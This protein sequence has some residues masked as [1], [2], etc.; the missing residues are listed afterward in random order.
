MNPPLAPRPPAPESG[1]AR[2]FWDERYRREGHIWGDAPSITAEAV[3]RFFRANGLRRV[4]IPG[5]AYG[6]HCLYFARK[7]FR[8]LGVDLSPAGL[9]MAAE[10]ARAAGVPVG[11]AGGDALALP[12]RDGALDGIYAFNL[13]HLFLAEGR[14]RCAAELCR[15]LRPSGWLCA[16]VFAREDPSFGKGQEVEPDT[17]DDR[18]GRPA[19]Y[20]TAPE[21]TELLRRAGFIARGVETIH[22]QEDHGAGPHLHVWHLLTAQRPP[23]RQGGN[24]S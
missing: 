6:R 15:I 21:L 1:A 3:A 7:G 8:V 13:L 16:T 9:A 5:C 23:G 10:G 17:F 4:C 19:H 14:G 24:S 20:F 2:R 18:G 11:L 12:I 22:E